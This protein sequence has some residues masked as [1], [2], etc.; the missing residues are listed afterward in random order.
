MFIVH[1]RR[2]IFRLAEAELRILYAN[3]SKKVWK[4]VGSFTLSPFVTLLISGSSLRDSSRP[5]EAA[6][7]RAG[8]R[9]LPRRQRKHRCRTQLSI[10]RYT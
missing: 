1:G 6:L 8:G 5:R 2:I 7:R 10:N 3:V 9:V 4:R